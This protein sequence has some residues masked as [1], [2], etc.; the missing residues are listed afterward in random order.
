[1]SGMA[2]AVSTFLFSRIVRWYPPDLRADFADDMIG[3]FA[4]SLEVSIPRAWL[5]VAHDF[6]EVV[7]PYRMAR[8]APV[9]AAIA[10]SLVFYISM[11]LAISPKCRK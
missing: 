3:V 11:L 8:V 5:T 4:Q 6:A 2:L 9:L 10:F 1:M 7:L